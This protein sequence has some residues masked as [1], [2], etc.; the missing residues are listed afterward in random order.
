MPKVNEWSEYIKEKRGTLSPQSIK[1]YA[2]IL[3]NLYARVFGGDVHFEAF[4]KEP[5]KVL[6]YLKDLT[7]NK[8]KTILSALV[9]ITNNEK[10]REKMLEDIKQYNHE[11]SKQEKTETQKENWVE[12]EDIEKVFYAC[13]A[14]ADFLMRKKVLTAD[15]LQAIQNFIILALLSGVYVPPRRSL[16]YT[17]MTIKPT[18]D[19]NLNTIDLKKKKFIFNR[20]KTAKTYG[21]QTLDI[22]NELATI[23]RKWIKIN[24][25]Q[26]LLFDTKGNK[27]NSVKLNQR[28]NAIFGKKVS[29]NNMRHSYLTDKYGDTIEKNKQIANTMSEMGSSTSMLPTYVKHD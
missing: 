5:E 9:V 29:V 8:R 3:K 23:L 20:Y 12:K 17:E 18:D 24:P 7:P 22:P 21:S 2:S 27:L 15:D 11:I 19:T 28:F 13:K 26:W 25:T 6:E 1:T 10:Y 4:E 14:N 16:D